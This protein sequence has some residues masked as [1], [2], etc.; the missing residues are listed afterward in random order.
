MS[1]ISDRHSNATPDLT[2]NFTIHEIKF[3]LAQEICRLATT[4]KN[5]PHVTP[6]SYIFENGKLAFATDYDTRKYRNIVK[7]KKVA[8]VVDTYDSSTINRA[9]VIEGYA[10]I[11]DNG[12]EFEELYNKFY[13]KFEWVRRE[14][15]KKGEAPFVIITPT[16]KMSWGI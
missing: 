16:H 5:T 11:V 15:W 3:L 1:N 12:A 9:V 10:E 13:K 4:N 7:N 6:V 8:I 14:P 2:V